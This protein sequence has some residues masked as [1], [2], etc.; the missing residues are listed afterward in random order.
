MPA[1]KDPFQALRDAVRLS[2]DNIPLRQH[3]ADTLMGKGLFEEAEKE[4]RAALSF[5]S[6]DLQLKLGLA[7]AFFKQ[8][9]K[10]AALALVENLID[11]QEVPAKAYVL[12]ARVLLKSGEKR[13][14][15]DAYK[16]AL[17]LDPSLTDPTLAEQLGVADEGWLEPDEKDEELFPLLSEMPEDAMDIELER[18]DMGFSEVGGMGNLKSEIRLKII[19]PL[20][21]SEIYD[22]YGRQIGG[23]ILMYGPPGCGKTH[24]ARAAAGEIKAA[25]IS[26]GI[27]DVLDMWIGSSERNLHDLFDF[28]RER[29]PCVLFFDEVDALGASRSDMRRSGNRQLIN[30]FLSE[31]DGYQNSNEG[32]LVLAATNAPWHLDPAFRRPGRFDRMVFVPPP[33]AA[34]RADILRILVKGKP[35]ADI[36]YDYLAQRTDGFSGADLKAAIDAAVDAKLLLAIE[37]DRVETLAT[38][39]IKRSIE[40]VRPTIKEWF[41]TARQYA[42]YANQS[43]MY[44]DIAKYLKIHDQ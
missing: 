13:D 33:D 23:G 43:G 14:A 17:Q 28:A 19:Y 10:S 20:T 40:T 37:K 31:L 3:F 8:N 2:P 24:F 41:A 21:H 6:E 1:K 34:A 38:N 9:K 22:A 32:V 4:Y 18:P 36:D 15:I 39:D 16:R 25:F 44:D 27:H 5:A 29:K 42:L 30:Q 12:Y 11:T 7:N 35:I 26:I